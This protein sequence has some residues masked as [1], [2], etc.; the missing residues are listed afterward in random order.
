MAAMSEGAPAPAEELPEPDEPPSGVSLDPEPP[1][2]EP[3][4]PEP[5]EPEL[6]LVA[7]AV[8]TLGVHTA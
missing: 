3:D 7:A 6:G 4:E 1:N 5:P 8:V 2:G